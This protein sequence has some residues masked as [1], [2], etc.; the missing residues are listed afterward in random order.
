MTNLIN[1]GQELHQ[2]R[3]KAKKKGKHAGRKNKTHPN[4]GSTLDIAQSHLR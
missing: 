2:K 1:L 4:R 3:K